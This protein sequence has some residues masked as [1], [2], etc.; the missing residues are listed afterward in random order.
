MDYNII[1]TEK[2]E[3]QTKKLYKK[4]ISI[5]SDI[6]KIANQILEDYQSGISLGNNTYKIRL[7][8]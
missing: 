5:V 4:Y 3:R 2:F 6:E 8:K 1:T 7:T